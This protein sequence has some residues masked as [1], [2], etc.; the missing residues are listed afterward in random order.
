MNEVD[1]IPEDFHQRQQMRRQ[2]RGFALAL[3]A[4]SLLLLLPAGWLAWQNGRIQQRVDGLQ[5]RNRIGVEQR[6]QLAGLKQQQQDLE[7]QLQLLQ[8]LRSG[9]A[10][11]DMFLLMDRALPDKGL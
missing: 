8:G 7:Q 6:Q 9:A 2:L 3:A 10:A 1:L 11:S 4:V 5:Q